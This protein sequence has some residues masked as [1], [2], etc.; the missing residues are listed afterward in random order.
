MQRHLLGLDRANP[1]LDTEATVINRIGHVL[2]HPK[3][4]AVI[5]ENINRRKTS[6]AKPLLTE[7]GVIRQKI[8]Q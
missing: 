6:H 8:S 1:K 2:S 3:L 4:L 7:L 5:V